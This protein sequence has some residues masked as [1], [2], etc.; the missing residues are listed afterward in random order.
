VFGTIS[1]T[2]WRSAT[3]KLAWIQ[4]WLGA[5]QQAIEGLLA[6]HPARGV[7]CHGDRPSIADICLVTQVTPAK[8]FSCML[9][10]YARVMRIYDTCM[11]I[12][13]FANAHPAK[14]PDAE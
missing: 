4:H 5:G 3:S 6:D 14:Q 11:A 9:D 8:T 12:P 1:G 7:F 2:C 10:A 13:A